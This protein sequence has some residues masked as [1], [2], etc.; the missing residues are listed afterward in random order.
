M[1]KGVNRKVVEI[2][3]TDSIYFEKAVF[4]L[5]PEVRELP[6]DISR[7][8]AEKYISSLVPDSRFPHRI[9]RKKSLIFL[10]LAVISA[11]ILI[12]LM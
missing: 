3:N 2:K 11:V 7:S 6:A 8:E 9:Y 5:R 4:Y 12:L 1:I 10:S